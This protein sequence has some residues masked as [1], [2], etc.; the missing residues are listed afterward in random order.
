MK[1]VCRFEHTSHKNE[2]Q[3]H[4]YTITNYG[5]NVQYTTANDKSPLLDKKGKTYIQQVMG[6]FIVYGRAVDPTMLVGLSTIVSDQAVPTKNT[7][8]KANQLSITRL[9]TQM[10]F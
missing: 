2:D 1:A 10:P 3:S 4:N 7:I 6:T 5:A 8:K 9:Y